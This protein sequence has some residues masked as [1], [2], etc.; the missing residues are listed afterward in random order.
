[1]GN[2][3][4]MGG[5][6]IRIAYLV[7]PTEGGIKVHLLTLLS[8]LDRSK[9]EPIV[10]CPPRI[11]L[12]AEV[13]EKGIP[14]IPL[15]IIGEISISKDFFAIIKLR[16]I[17]RDLR[18]DILHM[19]SFKAGLI[20]RLAALSIARRPKLILTEHAF[21]FDERTT[22]LK[23]ALIGGMGWF[24]SRFTNKIIT[25]SNALRNELISQQKIEPS[26]IVTIYNGV[27][28]APVER[29]IKNGMLVGTVSRLAPQKGVDYFIH[30]AALIAKQ[31]PEARFCI[32]GDG[33]QRQSLELLAESLR[34][35]D[36]IEFLG[37]RRDAL[38]IVR[39]FDVFVLASTR[40]S[41]GLT[42]VEALSQEIPVV[43]SRTGGI[44]EIVDNEISGLLAEPGNP[45]EIANQVCRLLA[46]PNLAR[47]LAETGSRLV[48]ERF[49]SEVMIKETQK[50]Y[51]EIL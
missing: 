14:A 7:R 33:P 21:I 24:F 22:N 3:E 5:R 12:F 38:D 8:G 19:H 41:F 30:A 27:T 18:P 4:L 9:F 23:R 47:Q 34:I 51:M 40:E 17:L 35:R 6:K 32:V 37:F 31:F 50:L 16:R 25:V 29:K 15:D 42:L 10:I 13:Q 2:G 49:S 45:H 20:G 43:A 39:T 48:R 28:F 26:K 44:V 36:K 11:S 46:D 1:M